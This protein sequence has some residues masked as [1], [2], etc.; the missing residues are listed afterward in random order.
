MQIFTLKVQS[1]HRETPDSITIC[2]K[3]PALKKVK[4]IAGQY[5][6]LL[7]TINGRKYRRAYSLSSAPGI[8]SSINITVKRVRHGIVSNFLIDTVKEEDLFEI[9][10]PMGDFVFPK[11]GLQVKH[12]VLWGAGSG[13]TP[14]YSILK[15]LVPLFPNISATLVYC[16]KRPEETIFYNNLKGLE[17]SNRANFKVYNFFTQINDKELLPLCHKGRLDSNN[18]S[19]I[20]DQ[21]INL[22]NIVHYICGPEGLKKVVSEN[23]LRRGFLSKYIFYENFDHVVNE[24]ELEG[25]HTR[26]VLIFF[27]E[28]QSVVEVVRG[29]SILEGGLDLGLDLPYSCQNGTCT[30]CRAELLNGEVKYIGLSAD[31]SRLQKKECLLCCSYPLS[32]NIEVKIAN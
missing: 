4:Y 8:D 2:F 5:I 30:L 28:T 10:E 25:V 23:L 6:T 26:N 29:K 22:D 14:L 3:Q 15:Y 11:E 1:I 7:L 13:I 20:L 31:E 12:V 19:F 32:D 24:N 17:D 16:N 9:I 27:N 18:I 21:L